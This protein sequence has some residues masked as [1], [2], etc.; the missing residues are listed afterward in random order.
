M[1]LYCF[2]RRIQKLSADQGKNRGRNRSFSTYFII[3][4]C[5]WFYYTFL[6]LEITYSIQG[7]SANDF[8][9]GICEKNVIT[10]MVVSKLCVHI[11][12]FKLYYI[13]GIEKVLKAFFLY[14]N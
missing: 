5:A 1:A 4:F 3:D 10:N 9:F 13:P 11:T 6:D 2:L 8:L 7:I 12:N 14:K